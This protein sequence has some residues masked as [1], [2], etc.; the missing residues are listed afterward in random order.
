MFSCLL[1]IFATIFTSNIPTPLY[2]MWQQDWG[3]SST[4]LTA[5]FSTYVLG[6]VLTLLTM[7]ALSDQL[8]RR[9]MLIP[10]L[11]FILCSAVIFMLATDIYHLGL[12]RLLTGVGTGLVTGAA[13]AGVVELEPNGDLAR[14]AALS[15]LAFT[16]G[17]STGPAISSATLYWSNHAHV[18][19]F[20]IAIALCALCIVLLLRARWPEGVGQRQPNFSMRS[21][22][23]TPIKVPRY[24]LSIFLFATAAICLAWS[25]GSL[26]SSLGPSMA[27]DLAGVTDL[28]LAGLFA[29]GW[30]LVAGLSQYASQRLP[31]G[32][33][34]LAGPL[35]LISGLVAMAGAVLLGSVGLFI[36][37]TLATAMGAGA[38]GVVA[39]ITVT[40]SAPSDERGSMVSALYL[41]AYISMATVVLGTGFAS[42][43]LGM[44]RSILGF[45]M[46]I[47]FAAIILMLLRRRIRAL[48]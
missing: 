23:P 6:V 13:T 9:Q 24:L 11:L 26:Y 27:R 7:G 35:L 15:A 32:W 34:I 40:R 38:I 36:L 4:A 8:G 39:I 43:Q 31:L 25:T 21:W 33:L 44:A 46:L 28:A 17:A 47:S 1:A 5:V 2:A 41:V 16:L 37:A 29:A 10:G 45:T 20:L 42:D 14:G 12:A 30:Q 22:R 48:K 19:P 18:W 3:F